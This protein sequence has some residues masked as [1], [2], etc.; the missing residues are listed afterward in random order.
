MK[1][2]KHPKNKALEKFS[3][4][5][6][7]MIASYLLLIFI[8]MGIY[9]P[10]LCS[11]KSLVIVWD[12]QY[13]FPLFRYLLS[14]TFFSSKLDLF[15]NALA[16][17]LPLFFLP[18][19]KKK[20]LF[21][22]AQTSLFLFACY[23][24]SDPASDGQLNK[25]RNKALVENIEKGVMGLD[26]QSELGFLN[27]YAK[28]N[29]LSNEI[30][31]KKQALAIE[32]TAKEYPRDK[33]QIWPSLW[34]KERQREDEQIQ[35]LRQN[36]EKQSAK[37]A[38]NSLFKIRY[39]EDR[40][41]WLAEEEKK[42]SF[43]V[44]TPLSHFHWEDDAGGSQDLNPYLKWHQRTRINRKDLLSALIFGIRISLFVGFSSVFLALCIAI[45]IGSICGFYGAW[46]DILLFRLLE[47][48]ESMPTLF[49]LLLLV[50]ILQSK[51]IFLIISVLGLFG[52]TGFCRF[53]RAET[54]RQRNL[55][56]VN[57]CKAMGFDDRFIIFSHV[58]PNALPPLWT[59]L[60]FSL[61]SA[62]SSEAG[63]SF[64]GLGP[65]GSCS[66]G[67]LM[68]EGRSA[69]PAE[70]YLLWPPGILLTS[71]LVLIAILGDALRDA[72]DPKST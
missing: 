49:V 46:L 29:L 44:N 42:I 66:W 12:Q 61:M 43:Q 68:D 25:K 3:R 35:T 10:F 33:G 26:W 16:I 72:F 54:L 55:P 37:D 60:P 65:E 53:I 24:K 58:L 56:Y 4:S 52:W 2:S 18:L 63:L 7:G 8:A 5:P 17:S 71:L 14:H 15:F 39:L 19:P 38:E 22:L 69:F 67:S 6:Q 30:R 40:R 59:L 62:I 11:S 64:L 27:D 48:W 36:A 32:E 13:Y 50:S 45:P 9:A 57:A 31:K 51:S 21:L 23:Q 41:A 20:W 47:I 28:L 1:T 34:H 70:S